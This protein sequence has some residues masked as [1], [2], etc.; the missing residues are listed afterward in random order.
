[1][2]ALGPYRGAG[3]IAIVVCDGLSA[4][5]VEQ[6]AALVVTA[7]LPLLG[8]SD[9]SLLPTVIATQARVAL[10]DGVG[11]ALDA[12]VVVVLIGERPGLSAADSLGAYLT[13]RPTA[14]LL[15]SSRNCI[16]NIRDGGLAPRMRQVKSQHCSGK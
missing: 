5:A 10:G 15:D 4:M 12:E 11:T 1:M 13:Y 14:G 16:S 7:L 6:N 9:F 3:D 2:A 8:L